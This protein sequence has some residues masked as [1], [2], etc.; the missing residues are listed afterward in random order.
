MAIMLKHP[1]D[2]TVASVRALRNICFR[3][4]SDI[5]DK[6]RTGRTP[7]IFLAKFD[8]DGFFTNVKWR[9]FHRA[10]DWWLAQISSVV[11]RKRYFAI[12]KD[13]SESVIPFQVWLKSRGSDISGFLDRP[14]ASVVYMTSSL[15]ISVAITFWTRMMSSDYFAGT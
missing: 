4:N 9:L 3:F 10:M 7:N 13:S 11:G 2:I 14:K 1:P 5:E 12:P 15:K 6:L 8:V